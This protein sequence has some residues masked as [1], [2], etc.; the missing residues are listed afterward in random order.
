[1]FGSRKM[2]I[3]AGNLFLGEFDVNEALKP[4]AAGDYGILATK[5]GLPISSQPVSFSGFINTSV[6]TFSLTRT[7]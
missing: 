7:R 2:P 1:M 5:F 6:E 3:A 4:N